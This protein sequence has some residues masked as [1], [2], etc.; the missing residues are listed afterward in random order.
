MRAKT[1]KM[2]MRVNQM[3]INFARNPHPAKKTRLASTFLSAVTLFGVIGAMSENA[4]AQESIKSA[5]AAKASA[6]AKIN[7]K[8]QS[9]IKP[10]IKIVIVTV[11]PKPVV[12]K[13][14]YNT[15]SQNNAAQQPRANPGNKSQPA[16]VVRNREVVKRT[17]PVRK[18]TVSKPVVVAPVQQPS[19]TTTGGSKAG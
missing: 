10:K 13:S 2:M 6:L 7:A 1:M 8:K 3:M 11:T 4:Q 12:P 19:Q 16:P 15:S 9:A 14:T 17:A 18:P 5:Q